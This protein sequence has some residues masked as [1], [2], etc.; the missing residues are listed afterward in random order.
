LNLDYKERT[1]LNMNLNSTGEG[2]K[3]ENL[4]N[5]EPDSLSE[6]QQ[7]AF[8][9]N[10]GFTSHFRWMP[11]PEVSFIES[12]DLR[13]SIEGND[14]QLRGADLD[15]FID[16][17]KRSQKF[18]LADV[19]AVMFAGPAGLAITK[20]GDY[21]SLAFASKGDSTHVGKFLAD[22]SLKDGELKTNDVA[23]STLRYR[24]SVDGK[25]NMVNDSLG[26]GFHVLDK[27]GCEMVGQRIYGSSKEIKMGRVNLIKTFLGPVKNFFYDLGMVKC[28]IV[29]SGRVEHPIFKKKKKGS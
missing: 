17:F 15:K 24:L 1:T 7:I 2:L 20:G 28:N 25:Y 10:V 5:A 23:L 8:N 9:G 21:A 3:L 26:F 4:L 11:E 19:S 16:N 22:W 12:V 27:K 29:Y 13:F 6:G 18:N 14:L